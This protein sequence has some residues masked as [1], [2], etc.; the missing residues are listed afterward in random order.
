MVEGENRLLQAVFLLTHMQYDLHD[1][2]HTSKKIKR[3][4][5]INIL[6][7]GN[8]ILGGYI[9]DKTMDI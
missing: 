7:N 8:F 9:C 3:V 6:E 1:C 5:V 4:N 2:T